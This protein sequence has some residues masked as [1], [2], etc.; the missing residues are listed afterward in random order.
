MQP[1]QPHH[2]S[3]LADIAGSH[4]SLEFTCGHDVL[5]AVEDIDAENTDDVKARGRCKICTGTD[6]RV[7]HLRIVTK[8]PGHAAP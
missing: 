7:L 8:L 4:L 1:S 6:A 3:R 5:V 2:G